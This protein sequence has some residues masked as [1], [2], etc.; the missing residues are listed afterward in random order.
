M[1]ALATAIVCAS[2]CDNVGGTITVD[3]VTATGSDLL[4]RTEQLRVTISSPLTVQLVTKI[5]GGFALDVDLAVAGQNAMLRVEALDG[6]G[7]VIGYGDTPRFAL[8]PISASLG[9]FIASPQTFSVAPVSLQLPRS[10]VG[11]AALRFGAMF[12]GGIDSMGAARDEVDIYSAF[13]HRLQIGKPLP[14]PNRDPIVV[15]NGTSVAYIVGAGTGWAFDTAVAPAGTY[16]ELAVNSA[17]MPDQVALPIA[18]VGINRFALSGSMSSVIDGRSLTVAPLVPSSDLPSR[19]ATVFSDAGVK[20]FFIGDRI[21]A[22]T[23]VLAVDAA[24]SVTSFADIPAAHRTGHV[25]VGNGSDI[26]VIGGGASAMM[27][28]SV[29]RI[30]TLTMATLDFPNALQPPRR[31]AA[32]AVAAGGKFL[33]IAGG[34]NAQDGQGLAS[35]EVFDA[36]TMAHVAT[37]PLARQR[38]GG[39]AI[40]LGNGQV[41]LAGGVDSLGKP[42]AE[43]ELFTPAMSALPSTSQ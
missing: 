32:A 27:A 8:G 42:I 20:A 13:T 23:S 34:S 25:V 15:N 9:V 31:A 39:T 1:I 7:Q 6:Q 11:I 22:A 21:N 37:L 5:D 2:G 12:A 28:A 29:L 40:S 41:L 26:F 4:T 38:I 24:G 16:A 19:G 36:A 18:A 30:D 3:I 35:A 14:S 17:S 33:V 43:I 10:N